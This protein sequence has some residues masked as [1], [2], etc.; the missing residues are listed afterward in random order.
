MTDVLT[1]KGEN[2]WTLKQ[3]LTEGRKCEGIQK[4]GA[5]YN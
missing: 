3:T 1:K 2:F 4:N 5:M